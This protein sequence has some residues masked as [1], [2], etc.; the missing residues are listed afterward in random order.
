[1]TEDHTV[2]RVPLVD[3]STGKRVEIGW[4]E[5]DP[6]QMFEPHN[7]VITTFVKAGHH[8]P[9]TG[10][11]V[12]FHGTSPMDVTVIPP[13]AAGLPGPS[14]I[15]GYAVT[16]DGIEVHRPPRATTGRTRARWT[17]P[18]ATG[19]GRETSPRPSPVEEST[20]VDA[21]VEDDHCATC[22]C[23]TTGCREQEWCKRT[24][25]HRGPC[26]PIRDEGM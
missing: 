17:R 5:V 19:E 3:Y 14:R 25:H 24:W 13:G 23:A 9:F 1:M 8:P 12:G 22:S 26:S 11:S 10:F 4:A 18:P 20:P 6:A 7:G 16:R 15:S 2:V 21:P